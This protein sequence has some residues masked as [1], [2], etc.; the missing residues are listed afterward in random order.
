MKFFEQEIN[1][2]KETCYHNSAQISTVVSVRSFINSNFQRPISLELIAQLH[3]V[4]KY[5]LLRLFKQYYGLTIRQYLIDVRVEKAKGFL[6]SGMSVTETCFAV[7]YES[8]SSFITLFKS[9]TGVTPF[10]F[11]KQQLSR[12]AP[13][14]NC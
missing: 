5:H 9:K 2:I 4:S 3:F 10:E 7:G 1:R 6:S 14:D 13:S 12:S 11:K 8:P